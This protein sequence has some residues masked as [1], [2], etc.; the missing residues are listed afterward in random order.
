[1][2]GHRRQFTQP[3]SVRVLCSLALGWVASGLVTVGLA[4]S[5]PAR[6]ASLAAGCAVLALVARFWRL[7]VVLGQ[8][9]VEVVNWLRTLRIPWSEVESFGMD[10][11]GNAWVR[12]S[13]MRRH[14]ISAFGAALR[15]PFGLTR[16]RNAEVVDRLE[17][18]RKK[19][20]G[21]GGRRG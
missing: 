9:S 8:E 1:M 7:R 18:A 2:S 15:D 13:D 5:G 3:T 11:D 14:G 16:R 21:R 4:D 17:R 19:R 6:Y 20:G 10:P 12:R